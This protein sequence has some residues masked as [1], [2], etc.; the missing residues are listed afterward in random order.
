VERSGT[1]GFNVAKKRLRPGRGA[2]IAAWWSKRRSDSGVAGASRT[3]AGA[4][5]F[6]MKSPVV[7]LRST[8]G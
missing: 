2:R 4:R 3:P 7:P 8:A 6:L 5:D 1:T